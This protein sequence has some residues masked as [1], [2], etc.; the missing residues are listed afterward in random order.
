MKAEGDSG[1]HRLTCDFLGRM[2]V[3]NIWERAAYLRKGRV[4]QLKFCSAVVRL[5]LA[6]VLLAVAAC[7]NADPDPITSIP[8][9]SSFAPAQDA[10]RLNSG[11]NLKIVVLG[12]EAI[13]GDYAIDAEGNVDV[14]N[15]GTVGVAGLTVREAETRLA[16]KLSNGFVQSPQV[17]V[18]LDTKRPVFI[19]GAVRNPGEYPFRTGLDVRSVIQLAGGYT[20]RANQSQVY[21][22]KAGTSQETLHQIGSYPTIAPGDVVRIPSG[23]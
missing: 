21:V 19:S 15:V 23:G 13:S 7:S 2:L 10:Y 14:S 18:L 8:Q 3:G 11:D 9:V 4:R 5:M 17:S 22:T 12:Q 20:E 1:R 16:E 6:A